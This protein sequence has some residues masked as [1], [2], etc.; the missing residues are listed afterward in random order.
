MKW[1]NKVKFII[2]YL[3]LLVIKRGILDYMYS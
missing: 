3:K 1:H 2:C